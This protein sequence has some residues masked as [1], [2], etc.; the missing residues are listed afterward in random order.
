[1][2]VLVVDDEPG[3]RDLLAAAIGLVGYDRLDMAE[4][5]E[6]ALA[7]TMA[8]RYDLV[9]LDIRMPG[10]LSGLETLPVIRHALPRAVIVIISAYTAD[11][12]DTDISD[13]DLVIKKPFQLDLIQKLAHQVKEL[14]QTQTALRDLS[15]SELSV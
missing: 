3:V 1:M 14:A 4:D 5:G 6:K 7:L 15:D 8:H 9:T 2:Q 10:A 11:A 12:I 13:A